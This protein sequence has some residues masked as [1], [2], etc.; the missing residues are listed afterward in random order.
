MLSKCHVLAAWEPLNV[1]Y[2]QIGG[3]VV[4]A[5]AGKPAAL[6]VQLE[7]FKRVFVGRSGHN[8]TPRRSATALAATTAS[9]GFSTPSAEPNIGPNG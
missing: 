9:P 7:A 1:A 2:R 6:H 8:C 4:T 5:E 3:R